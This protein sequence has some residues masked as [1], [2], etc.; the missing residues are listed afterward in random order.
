MITSKGMCLSYVSG[1]VVM[2]SDMTAQQK[3]ACEMALE[4]LHSCGVKHGDVHYG[5]FLLDENFASII[6]FGL[7]SICSNKA[8]LKREKEL[9][10][11]KLDNDDDS[12]YQEMNILRR[13]YKDF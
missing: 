2:F 13:L 6:Y 10:K 7:S 5:N 1:E 12:G 8:E 9:L 3:S 4:E 11:W